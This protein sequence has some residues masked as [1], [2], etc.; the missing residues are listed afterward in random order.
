METALH[1]AK[2]IITRQAE[3]GEAITQLKLQKLLYYVQG[4][5]L[6][7]DGRQR[8][9]DALEAWDY[10]PVVYSLRQEYGGHGRLPLPPVEPQPEFMDDALLDSVIEV[11][12]QHE[13]EQLIAL[14]HLER[15]WR[16]T[17]KPFHHRLVIPNE[18]ICDYFSSEAVDDFDIHKDFFDTYRAKKHGVVEWRPAFALNKSDIASLEAEFAE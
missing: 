4:W 9:T 6:A 17:Y 3:S 2:D 7:I 16:S 10:G 5:S 12:G 13:A 1:V 8:F 15:P 14:T 18:L 11:Y